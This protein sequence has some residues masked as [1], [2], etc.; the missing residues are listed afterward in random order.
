MKENSFKMNDVVYGNA[1]L[2]NFMLSSFFRE[3][4]S[5]AR[6]KL[7]R[8]CSSLSQCFSEK[9]TSSGVLSVM[10]TCR[11]TPFKDKL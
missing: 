5:E 4:S 7:K 10:I 9:Y 2:N 1:T 3:L 11:T 8:A 6:N